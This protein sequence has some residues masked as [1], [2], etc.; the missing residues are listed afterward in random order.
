MTD[1]LGNHAQK[2]LWEHGETIRFALEKRIERTGERAETIRAEATGPD[3][4]TAP[5]LA[6]MMTDQQNRAREALAAIEAYEEAS[7]RQEHP[8]L[9]DLDPSY[10]SE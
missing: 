1:T 5:Y 2:I 10:D 8:T 3:R 7:Y 6:N 9:T 4:H